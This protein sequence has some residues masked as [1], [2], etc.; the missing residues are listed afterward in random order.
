MKQIDRRRVIYSIVVILFVVFV[1]WIIISDINY[2]REIFI[3]F[4]LNIEPENESVLQVFYSA[5]GV[6]DEQK[7]YKYSMKLSDNEIVVP[8][9]NKTGLIRIDFPD[10]QGNYK[11]T[12]CSLKNRKHAKKLDLYVDNV[13]Q[14]T[15]MVE[16]EQTTPIVMVNVIG[17]DPYIVLDLNTFGLGQFVEKTEKQNIIV[18]HIFLIVC[19]VFFGILAMFFC[20]RILSFISELYENKT[21]ILRLAKND[22]KTKYAGS[23]FGMI[24]AFV[25]PVVTVLVYWFVFQVGFNS[26]S[27]DNFPFVIWLIAGMVPWFLFNDGWFGGTNCLVEYSYL[28]K[29]VV[30]KI[31]ILPIVKILSALFVNIFFIILLVVIYGAYGYQYDLYCLQLIYYLGCMVVLLLGL[32]YICC[33]LV[34]FFKDLTQVINIILQIGVWITPIMWN[35]AMFP[36]Q[37]AWILKLNPIFYIVQ[38]FRNSLLY[39][40][41]FWNDIYWTAYFWVI[42][43]ALLLVGIFIFKKLRIHFSNVL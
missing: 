19:V 37:Y 42:T 34:V 43:S 35:Q 26:N 29:K 1:S 27:V 25:Q 5:D 28:V 2:D 30:F 6:W 13:L 16:I 11:I 4:K 21:M 33:S 12:D 31:S 20:N 39:K 3:D 41:W 40:Q 23:Y 38:G 18:A 15:N 8:V 7:S 24:W 22:F 17:P 9:S 32:S 14:S 10:V 36:K